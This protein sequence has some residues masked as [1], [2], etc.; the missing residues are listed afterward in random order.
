MSVSLTSYSSFGEV[1]EKQYYEMRW[2][3][4]LARKESGDMWDST[5]ADRR[6]ARACRESLPQAMSVMESNKKVT[7]DMRALVEEQRRS[8]DV[9][10]QRAAML[11][12]DLATAETEHSLIAEADSLTE[13]ERRAGQ[14]RDTQRM[15]ARN[16]GEAA[17]C[18]FLFF[19]LDTVQTQ[20]LIHTRIHSPL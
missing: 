2:L 11:R 5:D 4:G 16:L 7:L 18:K 14:E 15:R 19:F 12:A 8:E 3:L 20:M 6:E 9:L 17:R 13:A 1:A 10:R